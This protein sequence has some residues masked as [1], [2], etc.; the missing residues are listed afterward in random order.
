MIGSSL[1]HARVE[2]IRPFGKLAEDTARVSPNRVL[3]SIGDDFP[4]RYQGGQS[5]S[6]GS[7]WNR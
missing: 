5:R 1:G 3:D 7:M 2:T 4:V 6:D